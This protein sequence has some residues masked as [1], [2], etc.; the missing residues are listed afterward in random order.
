MPEPRTYYD[1]ENRPPLDP[2]TREAMGYDDPLDNAQF[3]VRIR[4]D[5]AE[6]RRVQLTRYRPRGNRAALLKDHWELMPVGTSEIVLRVFDQGGRD[7]QTLGF[8]GRALGYYDVPREQR[9]TTPAQGI[10]PCRIDDRLIHLSLREGDAA[11]GF[12]RHEV[13]REG[14]VDPERHRGQLPAAHRKQLVEIPLGLFALPQGRG[15]AKYGEIPGRGSPLSPLLGGGITIHP[16]EYTGLPKPGWY[17]HGYE[18]KAPAPRIP[19]CPSGNDL[20][21]D[22]AREGYIARTE[23]VVYH[24]PKEH[25]YNVVILGDGFAE[26]EQAKFADWSDLLVRAMSCEC[27]LNKPTDFE[28]RS[29]DEVIKT[30]WEKMNV[31]RAFAVSPDSGI[32]GCPCDCQGHCTYFG[33]QGNWPTTSGGVSSPTF[34]GTPYPEKMM[35][36]AK[37]LLGEDRANLIVVLVNCHLSGGSAPMDQPAMFVTL[38]DGSCKSPKDRA[39]QFVDIALHEMG[40]KIANLADEYIAG[41]PFNL[42]EG[43]PEFT[44]FVDAAMDT[45]ADGLAAGGAGVSAEAVT[46]YKARKQVASWAYETKARIALAMEL[47]AGEADG[48]IRVPALFTDNAGNIK[49]DTGAGET[50]IPDLPPNLTFHTEVAIHDPQDDMVRIPS[51]WEDLVDGVVERDLDGHPFKVVHRRTV[52]N[53]AKGRYDGSATPT[54][55]AVGWDLGGLWWGCQHVRD[56]GPEDYVDAWSDPAGRNYFRPYSTCKMRREDHKFCPVCVDAIAKAICKA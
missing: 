51:G 32:D 14:S 38:G 47:S 33:V 20:M 30:P 39:Q 8:R 7:T 9:A 44:E 15:P 13:I 43:F 40:H 5:K 25:A 28:C 42:P 24:K 26:H 41:E 6:I 4:G 12:F 31:Y 18:L 34:C 2:G 52:Y 46:R 17:A 11:I 23:T 19:E 35:A 48:H 56:L 1:L 21:S 50:L 16:W 55:T 49:V 45:A 37:A 54:N 36:V 3:L 27:A 22:K 10:L 53:F 29:G